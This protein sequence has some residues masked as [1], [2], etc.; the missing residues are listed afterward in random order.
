[1]TP[2]E[3]SIKAL[4]GAGNSATQSRGSEMLLWEF[5]ITRP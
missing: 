5:L 1:M 3:T 2:G 4:V